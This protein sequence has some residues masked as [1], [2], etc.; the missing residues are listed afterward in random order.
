MAAILGARQHL[1]RQA[2][3]K[4]LARDLARMHP[5]LLS[6]QGTQWVRHGC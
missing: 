5:H 3:G 6:Q 2:W 1:Q 4:Q